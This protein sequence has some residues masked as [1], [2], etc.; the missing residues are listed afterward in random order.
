[1]FV[2]N[3]KQFFVGILTKLF[4]LFLRFT[5]NSKFRDCDSGFKIYKNNILQK[6]IKNE[7]VNPNFIS[8]ELC[9]KIQYSGYSFIEIPVEYFQR[10]EVSKA[11][12]INKIPALI[13][14]FLLNFFKFKDQL[15]KI[16][17]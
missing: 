17:S 16:R 12:P 8:A 10:D 9:L 15:K 11:S 13:I 2:W 1:M 5:L 6:I 4:N 3:Q 14:N 7:V